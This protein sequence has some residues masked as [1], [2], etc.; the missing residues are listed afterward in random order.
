MKRSITPN[1]SCGAA[2][3]IALRLFFNISDTIPSTPFKNLPC[4][5]ALPVSQYINDII[6]DFII[7]IYYMCPKLT[8]T[9]FLDRKNHQGHLRAMSL[10]GVTLI[11]TD[12]RSCLLSLSKECQIHDMTLH[13]NLVTTVVAVRAGSL[14][15]NNCNLLD[16]ST[17]SLYTYYLHGWRHHAKTKLLLLL[18]G[19]CIESNCNTGHI[20]LEMNK[21]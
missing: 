18:R 21:F 19:Y 9:N 11:A 1:T 20:P 17:N 14:H 7:L 6:I 16:D 5:L 12:V 10:T 2:V 15:L 3:V 4:L 13:C 8:K